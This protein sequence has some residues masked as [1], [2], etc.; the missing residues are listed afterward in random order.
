[1]VDYLWF[2]FIDIGNCKPQTYRCVSMIHKNTS[3]KFGAPI[4][5][6]RQKWLFGIRVRNIHIF[7]FWGI[8]ELESQT[9]HLSSYIYKEDKFQ[10]TE[11]NS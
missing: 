1:M 10:F 3:A 5:L 9:W 8:K 7:Y 6:S 4:P 2:Y 11:S